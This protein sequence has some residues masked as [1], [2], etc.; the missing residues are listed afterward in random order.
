MSAVGKWML[1]Y[2][3]G[4]TDTYGQAQLDLQND[5]SVSG[6]AAGSWRQKDGTVLI[7]FKT[8]PAKYGG[9]IDAN[10][11]SGAMTTFNGLDGTWYMI[12]QGVVG[13]KAKSNDQP[14]DV[15]GNG[16]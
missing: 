14:H 10:V 13:L 7:A 1:H 8:G 11:A 6:A 16:H 5:G 4:P 15:T 3:W 2:S 12:K 9:T